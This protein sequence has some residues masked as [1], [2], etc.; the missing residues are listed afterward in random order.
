MSSQALLSIDVDMNDREWHGAEQPRVPTPT[1]LV[2]EN[3]D[4]ITMDQYRAM[5]V[6]ITHVQEERLVPFGG[7]AM[8]CTTYETVKMKRMR[9]D[10]DDDAPRHNKKSHY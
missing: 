3:A 9:E 4:I 6:K 1:R 5:M 7:D 2:L 10:V 8:L